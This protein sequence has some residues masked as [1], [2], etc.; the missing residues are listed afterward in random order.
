MTYVIPEY[1]TP[2]AHHSYPMKIHR[3]TDVMT[4]SRD[5]V[6]HMAH[7]ENMNLRLR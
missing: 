5:N 4:D 2:H 3:H 7:Y 6:T 1:M